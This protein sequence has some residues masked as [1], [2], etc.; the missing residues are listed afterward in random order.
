MNENKT[1]FKSFLTKSCNMDCSNFIKNTFFVTGIIFFTAS[2]I[3]HFAHRDMGKNRMQQ[4]G[5]EERGGRDKYMQNSFKGSAMNNGNMQ[6]MGGE[7][8]MKMMMQNQPINGGAPKG[9]TNNQPVNT[10]HQEG[11]VKTNQ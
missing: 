5:R 2:T 7:N 9:F 1:T 10:V 6:N 8:Q 4:N 11:M 3:G